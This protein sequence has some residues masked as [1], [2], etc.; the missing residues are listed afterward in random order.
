MSRSSEWPVVVVGCGPVGMTL[1]N[2][3]GTH[4]V[5]A[6]LLERASCIEPLPRAVGVDRDCLRAWQAAGLDERLLRD[7]TPMGEDGL[8]MIYLDP[9]GRPFMELR[10]RAREFGFAFGYGFVQPLADRVLLE[11]LARFEH[12]EVAFGHRVEAVE[13]DTDGVTLRVRGPDG[14]ERCVRSRFVVACDGGRSELR[15]ALGIA[16]RGKT[17]PERW[18]V[19]DLLE[20]SGAAPSRDVR[21][22]CDAERPTVSVPR[23]YGHRRLELRLRADESDEEA[24]SDAR[25]RGLLSE[26]ADPDGV[27]VLRK[28]V[29]R[30]NARVADRFRS[31]RV[32]LAG[33]A[34]HVTPP[35]AAQGLAMGVRDVFNL[36]WK[37]AM[38]V[39]GRAGPALLDSYEPERRP[40]ARATVRLAVWLGRI[41]MPASRW[42]A[43]ALP[44]V[45]RF[46]RRSRRIER[47][48]REGGPK[49]RPR[50][51]GN[52]VLRSR[53]G[54]VAGQWLRQ[55]VVADASGR[56]D[57]LDRFLG[58][59]FALLGWSVDPRSVLA[60]E[61]LAS[62][63]AM[64]TAVWVLRE[65]GTRGLGAGEL[66]DVDGDWE[67]WLGAAQDR[68]L[69]VRPDRFV[70]ADLRAADARDR[71]GVAALLRRLTGERP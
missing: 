60:P 43:V 41:M 50:V 34:A 18:L 42:R 24:L 37:L 56:R 11:G 29:Y 16:M 17:Q 1:G 7:M 53:P 21:I 22:H 68:I 51:R 40:D 5:P 15:R 65:S 69:L 70:A 2:L 8:G 26:L 45:I 3:L 19:L 63:D 12:L 61:V 10:P 47:S 9:A 32:F 57:K 62:L 20:P 44:A 52:L 30:F 55:P 58:E 38:V 46:L 25:V 71:A 39:D 49:P 27:R 66:C 35:F 54:G 13:P 48:L 4:D 28:L 31:G 59:G 67:A 6:L 36:A 33:D 64:G 14:L 23:C